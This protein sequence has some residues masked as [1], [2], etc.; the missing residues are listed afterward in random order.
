MNSC[1]NQ[2]KKTPP[3]A[4]LA[5]P[6]AINQL[7]VSMTDYK[8]FIKQK[9]TS[10]PDTGLSVIPALNPMLHEHQADNQGALFECEAA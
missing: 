10:D 4:A 9:A 2:E 5:G 8:D 6:V 1:A 3:L 7:E